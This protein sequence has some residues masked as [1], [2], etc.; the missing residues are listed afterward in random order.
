MIAIVVGIFF[1]LLGMFGILKWAPDLIMVLRGFLPISLTLGGIVG[2]MAGVSALQA[3]RKG[4]ENK[5]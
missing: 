4:N 5:K 1:I 3:R 2:L